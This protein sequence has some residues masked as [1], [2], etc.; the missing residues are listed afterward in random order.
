MKILNAEQIRKADAYT[1]EHEP[2]TSIDLMERAAS[3]CCSWINE[4]LGNNLSIKIFAGPGNN[5]GDGLAMARLLNEDNQV[6]VY[7]LSDPDKLS[8]DARENY[9][10]L[11]RHS[12]DIYNLEE[13]CT[14]PEIYE[15]DVVID[16]MF[17]SG[18]SRPLTGLAARVVQH[19]NE[20]G[21][22]VIA[23][24][25]PSGLYCDQNTYENPDAI[26]KAHYTLT[27][28]MPKLSFFFAENQIFTG[29]WYY[30]DIELLPEAIDLQNSDYLMIE[31]EDVALS[32]KQRGKFDHKGTFGHALLMAGSFG[33]MGAAVLA[34]KACLRSGAGLITTHLPSKGYEIIQITVPEAMVSADASSDHLSSLPDLTK[35]SAI[36]VGP[37]IGTNDYTGFLLQQL[38]KTVKAPLVLDAD[39]LNLLAAHPERLELL[40]KNTILTP[41]PG[42]FDRLAGP[43]ANGFERHLKQI[44]FSKEQK[45]IIVLKGAHTSITSP[46]GCCRFNT[47]GN[48]GMATA[49]S[50]DVL[51]GIILSL[52]AQGYEPIQAAITGVYLHGLA[53]DIAA[54]NVGVES[55][56]AS[57]II[58]NISN[59]FMT[60][61]S[62]ETEL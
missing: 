47:T 28:Q 31:N 43:S 23:V 5:G 46:D 57:D 59:A 2:I 45:V 61:R 38:L 9:K 12:D 39:A 50:G 19:I 55:L 26:V 15:A 10:R 4:N 13:S 33:K 48:P 52:L 17:G 24:D 29:E 35:F 56:I 27:F 32:L 6:T 7:M 3:M 44:K 37:G 51:T 14:L 30:L 18:L 36:G 20:S 21:A 41:H 54:S 53:G 58:K 8:P 40:P 16:A 34:S 62:G 1:I 49:G 42:E 25:L 11:T 60:I 22:T